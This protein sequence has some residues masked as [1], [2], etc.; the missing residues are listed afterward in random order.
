MSY[1]IIDSR[2]AVFLN[3]GPLIEGINF[4]DADFVLTKHGIK[5]CF[6]L[7]KGN[8]LTIFDPSSKLKNNKCVLQ[9]R[10]DDKIDRNSEIL[11]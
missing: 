2:Y 3:G 6:D 10:I 1:T 4:N 5:F 9:I 8:L 11:F 7:K